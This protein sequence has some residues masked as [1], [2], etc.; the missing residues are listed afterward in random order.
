ML[1]TKRKKLVEVHTPDWAK[2]KHFAT[3]KEISVNDAV[4]ILLRIGLS[5]H[6]YKSSI[7]EQ[8]TVVSSGESLSAS[9]QNRPSF[10]IR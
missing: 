7:G 8:T 6:G 10:E 4:Q 2:V 3:M 9:N 5:N 1:E